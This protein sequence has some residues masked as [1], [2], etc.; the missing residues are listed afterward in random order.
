MKN[1]GN[2]PTNTELVENTVS[3]ISKFSWKTR[4]EKILKLFAYKEEGEKLIFPKFQIF[5]V[6]NSNM[7]NLGNQP[8]ITELIENTVSH[9]S[10]ISW[11]TREGKILK[12]FACKEEGE[13]LIFPKFQIFPV[14]NSNMKNL[15]NQPTITELIENTVSHISK[16][17]WKTREGKILKLFACK[18]EGKKLIFPKFQIFQV[19]NYNMRNLGNQPTITEIFENPVSLISKFS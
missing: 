18:E 10:K 8:T 7:K 4:E 13:K 15:G 6:E 12:L 16:I 19:E 5:P 11:K 9:I 17:S 3:H 1:L 2:Q 14:E